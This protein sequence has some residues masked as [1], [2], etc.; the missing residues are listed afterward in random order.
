MTHKIIELFE[1]TLKVFEDGK[2][3]VL[4]KR[5]PNKDEYYEK[6]CFKNNK[7]YLNLQLNHKYKRKSYLIHRIIAFAFLELDI[8]NTK[9][10]INHQD[11]DKSNNVVSNLRIV[12]NQQNLFNTNAKGYCWNKQ[13]NK[14]QSSIR[15]D[16]K[17]I[18]LG[19]FENEE[20][21][22]QAYEDAKLI[23]HIIE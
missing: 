19:L 12:T 2:V 6:K 15:G 11:I 17:Q 5:N 3:L 13:R 20:D 14:W 4:G 1:N 8:E 22:K 16:G 9:Q 21:A 7:G 18:H 23:Y 10:V